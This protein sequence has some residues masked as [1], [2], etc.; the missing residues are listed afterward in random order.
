MT[1]SGRDS[2]L[3]LHLIRRQGCAK[4]QSRVTQVKSAGSHVSVEQKKAIY[5]NHQTNIK[6]WKKRKR[7][8]MDILDAILEGYPKSKKQL[9]EEVGVETDEECNVKIPQT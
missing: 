4:K 7:M 5:E 2:P 1:L 8:A 3:G 6:A 9:V